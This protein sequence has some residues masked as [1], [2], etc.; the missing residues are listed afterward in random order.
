M[1][2]K[3]TPPDQ[4][5]A[6]AQ[7][8]R[9]QTLAQIG[10]VDIDFATQTSVVSRTL[11]EML[12]QPDGWA[13]SAL[14]LL[15]L[16]PQHEQD[17]IQQLWRSAFS[18]QRSAVQ[19]QCSIVRDGE[20]R[21]LHYQ[22]EI[23]YTAK[24]MPLRLFAVVQDLTPHQKR[25]TLLQVG[26]DL[27][28]LEDATPDT[29]VHFD[30]HCRR[31]YVN[32]AMLRLSGV[33]AEALLGRKPTDDSDSPQ[34]KDL[35][36]ELRACML[37]GQR[38][39]H[40]YTYDYLCASGP[41]RGT[42]DLALV[43]THNPEGHV[44]GAFAIGRDISALKD[45]QSQ[46]ENS[47]RMVRMGHWSLDLVLKQAQISK[48]GRELLGLPGSADLG[49]N[50]LEA[51]FPPEQVAEIVRAYRDAVAHQRT[52]FHLDSI[53]TGAND[54]LNDLHSW[55]RLEYTNE[56]LPVRAMGV[57]QDL[58]AIKALQRQTHQLAYYDALTHLPN[59]AMLRTSLQ[60]A[61]SDSTRHQLTF[62][63]VI[64]GIDHFQKVNDSLGQ[65]TGDALL[66]AI[67]ARLTQQMR[68]YD[69][70]ARIGG[71]EFA[72][73][74]PKIRQ[75]VDVGVALSHLKDAFRAPIHLADTEIMVTAS[76]GIAI[77]PF[78]GVDA[79]E[80]LAHA[81][82]A[83]HHAKRSGRDNFQYYAPELTSSALERLKIESDLRKAVVRSELEL[84]Y[85]PKVDLRTGELVGAE[86]LMRWHHPTRGLVP[87]DQFISIAEDTSLILGMGEWALH[88]ACA[89]ARQWNEDGGPLMKVAI[90]LSARQFY[91][92]DLVGT[93]YTALEATGCKAEWIEL[94]I[95]ESLLLNDPNEIRATLVRLHHMGIT[96]AIDDFGTGYSALSYLAKFPVDTLKIDRAFIRDLSGQQDNGALVQAIVSLARGLRMTLVAEGVET[97]TQRDELRALS[98]ELAQGFF[99]SKPVPIA[100]FTELMAN[101]TPVV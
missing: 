17:N 69:T 82:A 48:V 24:G 35:E 76:A 99:Y 49:F 14:E 5:P 97:Q 53:L 34:A 73:V 56:G 93:V 70:V 39:R 57:T 101:W 29:I 59:R 89:A 62:G 36:S 83:M 31:T 32:P 61:I 40:L 7:W 95:T 2:K 96:I 51:H 1:Q 21:Q 12:G 71:D 52:E 79:T 92:N 75:A 50:T 45:A 63:L 4:S 85:Q 28:A 100:Q 13:P 33:P 94:E 18:T 47:Q 91:N 42:A 38:R 78:D 23:S 15:R 3:H 81:D 30:L 90:N 74:V 80:L 11:C 88:S 67:A 43:P 26:C 22:G 20:T 9:A 65:T 68:G 27:K 84:Y 64:L 16:H 41:I 72:L 44:V 10:S 8:E 66:K 46:L 86:A 6:Q 19:Y 25:E 58:T 37:E 60:Q 87:P 54:S 77:F 55:V 98:C